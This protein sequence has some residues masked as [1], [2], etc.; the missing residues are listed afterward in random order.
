MGSL[1]KD[2][3]MEVQETKACGGTLRG[4][5]VAVGALFNQAVTIAD[6]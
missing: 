5:G 4:K 2:E 3:R 1:F 6:T